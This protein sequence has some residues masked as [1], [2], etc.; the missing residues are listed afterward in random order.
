MLKRV[1]QLTADWPRDL[2][3]AADIAPLFGLPDARLDTLAEDGFVPH[4]RIDGGRPLYRASEVKAWAARNLLQKVDGA[5]LPEPVRVVI[6]AP[7]PRDVWRIPECI[8]EVAGLR[9]ISGEVSRVGIYFLC[10]SAEVV[11][12]GQS[13]NAIARVAQHRR[14][15]SEGGAKEFD[16]VYFLPWPSES[17]DHVEGALIRWLR[18]RLNG[19]TS[20]GNM[21]SF[22][23]RRTDSIVLARLGIGGTRQD[24]SEATA[25]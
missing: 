10:L 12:V 5:D 19:Q 3:T 20:L 23:D 18:P 24:Q 8:R 21:K 1:E 9:D 16:A 17:L 7:P 4:Y 13:T 11:Y 2:K 6:A 14:A 15:S 25:E 22:G